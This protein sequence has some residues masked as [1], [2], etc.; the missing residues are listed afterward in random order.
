MI[1][2]QQELNSILGKDL[3][4]NF[5]L[6]DVYGDMFEYKD[7]DIEVTF[8]SFS[9]IDWERFRSYIRT[10]AGA[11]LNYDSEITALNKAFSNIKSIKEDGKPI[12]FDIFSIRDKHA[13]VA[14][15]ARLLE[16]VLI[17]NLKKK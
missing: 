3:E 11:V 5:K 7:T 8:E 13:Y 16:F 4:L 15:I 12:D 9:Y 2:T 10:D 6:S 17:P 1:V 14:L